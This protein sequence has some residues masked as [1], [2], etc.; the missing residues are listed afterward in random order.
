MPKLFRWFHSERVG[1]KNKRDPPYNFISYLELNLTKN[2]F[3]ACFK[4][5]GRE[6]KPY[7]NITQHSKLLYRMLSNIRQ[8]LIAED[9]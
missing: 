8:K 1:S 7:F 4:E 9:F 5:L 6:F 3:E 2:Y